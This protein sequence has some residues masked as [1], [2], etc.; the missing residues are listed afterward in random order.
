MACERKFS[1]G[2][3]AGFSLS[4]NFQ[5]ILSEVKQQNMAVACDEGVY[6]IAKEVQ[7]K[8]AEE[9]SNIVLILG[10]FYMIKVVQ[11]SIGQY[12]EDSGAECGVVSIL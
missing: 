5:Y 9:F 1:F 6:R 4:L 11:A 7:L 8:H 2:T 3:W 10:P 12:I